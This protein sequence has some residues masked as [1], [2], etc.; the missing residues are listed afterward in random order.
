M[1][2][3]VKPK[4]FIFLLLLF[5]PKLKIQ[6]KRKLKFLVHGFIL[7]NLILQLNTSKSL[8]SHENAFRSSC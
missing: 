4:F 6:L 2:K 1:R 3:T 8:T 7:R 5:I